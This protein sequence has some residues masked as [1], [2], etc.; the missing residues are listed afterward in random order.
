MPTRGLEAHHTH[1]SAMRP[2]DW[3]MPSQVPSACT[4]R[5]EST[6]PLLLTSSWTAGTLSLEGAGAVNASNEWKCAGRVGRARY[7]S[8]FAHRMLRPPWSADGERGPDR[9]E[10]DAQCVFWMGEG[11]EADAHTPQ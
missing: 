3:L 7:S 6:L 8:R 4:S 11:P 2:V 5:P 1:R 9:R 10:R